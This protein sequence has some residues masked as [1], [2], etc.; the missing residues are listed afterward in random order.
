MS[1]KI[2]AIFSCLLLISSAMQLSAA[3]KKDNSVKLK[4]K[5]VSF[6]SEPGSLTINNETND[7]LVIF[8][9]KV[10]KSAVL[11][12]ISKCITNI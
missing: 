11:G 5:D 12:G 3:S 4:K 8:V 7:D 6:K 1:K 9:G 2:V 10:E